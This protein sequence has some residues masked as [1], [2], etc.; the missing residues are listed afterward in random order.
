MTHDELVNRI[1]ELARKAKSV[2]G[3]TE[4]E[5]EERNS[6]R[7]QYIE[8]FRSSLRSQLDNIRFTD[9]DE[10]QPIKH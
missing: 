10:Q 7:K 4:E 1:N 5:V 3:L 6:L 2:E 8:A 9:E